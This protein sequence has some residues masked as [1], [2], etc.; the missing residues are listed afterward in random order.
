MHPATKDTVRTILRIVDLFK[1]ADI[2][3][4][5]SVCTMHQDGEKL[6]LDLEVGI[7]HFDLTVESNGEVVWNDFNHSTFLFKHNDHTEDALLDLKFGLH[8]VQARHVKL[9]MTIDSVCDKC[10]GDH[11]LCLS[12]KDAAEY[13][14]TVTFDVR[15]LAYELLKSDHSLAYISGIQ[16]LATQW[17]RVRGYELV[18]VEN[19][20]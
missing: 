18:K 11:L 17:C 16:D 7:D 6:S 4:H 14:G 10:G 8:R 5:V 12:I 1:Q 15:A 3:P 13:E 9:G 20:N 19:A 2:A